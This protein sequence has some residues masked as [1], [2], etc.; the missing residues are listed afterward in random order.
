MDNRSR[1]ATGSLLV[2]LVFLA[3]FRLESA[4]PLWWDEG[5]TL[6]VARN[7]VERGHYGRLLDGKLA[8]P[9][10]EAAFPITVPVAVSFRLLGVG[11]DQGRIPGVG[12]TLLTLALI[13]YLAERLYNRSVALATLVV[14]TFMPAYFDLHPILTGR[15]VL[16]EI[17]SLFYLLAGY[18]CFLSATRRP[19]GALTSG[20]FFWS[21]ALLSKGQ[22]L[23][24][25]A[26]SMLVPL[27]FFVYRRDWK[28][29]ALF[30]IP[31]VVSLAAYRFVISVV[32][33]FLQDQK[34]ALAPV[35]GLYEV[36]ALVG[37]IPAHLFAFIV[38]FLFGIPTLL[39]LCY[40][41]WGFIVSKG[42]IQSHEDAVRLSLLVLAGSWFC[43]YVVFS[44]GWI[45][46]LFPATFIGSIFEAA[47]LYDLT[48]RY[49]LSF[50]SYQS[51]SVL[52]RFNFNRHSLG[53]LLAAFL[54]VTSVPR[55]LAMFY[56]TYVSDAD[57][58]VQQAARFLNIYAA[59]GALI[60]TYDS[61][62]LFLLHRRYH[63]PPDQVHVKLIRRTF[64]YQDDASIDYDPLAA[65]PDY[66]VV[67]PHSK[68]WHLYDPVLKTGAFRLLR[69]YTRYDLY[70]RV[71]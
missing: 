53:A 17:P 25:W 48:N 47:M 33:V 69:R 16:G 55:T 9:G 10:L 32:Q 62:L 4:P 49:S 68:Q 52:S 56:K 71:R 51:A 66:L 27:S 70:E 23:P 43:W 3:T 7:W 19:V 13:Y 6:S 14:L 64:L 20:T 45:R 44:V 31:F 28:I 21:I 46:Y 38:L 22:V 35:A 34:V 1:V 18:T 50:T 37:S 67:G 2:F 29:A 8:P 57:V 58:S 15:Q 63:Y 36:T 41:S 61:E 26:F 11:V 39:A 60:E 65:N 40:V 42:H 24:F 54:V 5:W 12:Y 30:G 59:P